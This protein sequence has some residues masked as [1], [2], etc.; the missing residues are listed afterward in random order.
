MEIMK[1]QF[2]KLAFVSLVVSGMLLGSVNASETQPKGDK[3]KSG[4]TADSGKPKP[5]V[6]ITPT[7]EKK[8]KIAN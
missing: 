1:I 5:P 6:V 8:L 2:K 4:E 3:N 7:P